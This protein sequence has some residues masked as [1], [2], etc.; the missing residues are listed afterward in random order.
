MATPSYPVKSGIYC[1]T[2]SAI[3]AN[4]LAQAVGTYYS[5]AAAFVTCCNQP[6]WG[7]NRWPDGDPPYASFSTV[8]PPNSPNCVSSGSNDG[9]TPMISSLSSNH[10]GGA[11]AGM[12]DGSCRFVTDQIDTGMLT[13]GEVISGPSP[14]G[15]WGALGSKE[16]GEGR[17]DPGSL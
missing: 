9:N 13:L 5:T 14:Y 6:T 8:L 17:T 12:A 11:L 7:S 2:N 4:C 15:V 16:G 3:P 10:P 1:V